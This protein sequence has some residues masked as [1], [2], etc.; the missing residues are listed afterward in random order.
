MHLRLYIDYDN[1]N[2]GQKS[3]GLLDLVSRSL[4]AAIIPT[5]KTSGRCEV[6]V[7]G[8][9]YEETSLTP[10]AQKIIGEI[11]DS[12]PAILPVQNQLGQTG[13]LTV[14]ADLA[15]SLE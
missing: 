10:L 14:S 6:R 2:P 8:G 4:L 11:G 13:R 7:Y 5:T 12:F 15:R 3:K 9:W 1:L